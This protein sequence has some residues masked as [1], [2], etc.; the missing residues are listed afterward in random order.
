MV[1]GARVDL[2]LFVW[3][4]DIST[5]SRQQVAQKQVTETM[6][7]GTRVGLCGFNFHIVGCTEK[8]HTHF[9]IICKH[10]LV[11]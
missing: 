9:I 8:G 2:V 7:C 11:V 5:T 10:Q 1:H 3:Q 4:T 6:M